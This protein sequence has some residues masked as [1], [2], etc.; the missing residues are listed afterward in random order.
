VRDGWHIQRAVLWFG[1][2]GVR[3]TLVTAP[4]SPSERARELH[5]HRPLHEFGGHPE[6]LLVRRRKKVSMLVFGSVPVAAM[7]SFAP[8]VLRRVCRHNAHTPRSAL[9]Y[10]RRASRFGE[11]ATAISRHR[12]H[13]RDF[14]RL[15]QR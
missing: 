10:E 9:G 6:L 11:K 8:R 14:A 15:R 5:V 13:S 12:S 4:I 7:R 1:R 3:V 2:Y